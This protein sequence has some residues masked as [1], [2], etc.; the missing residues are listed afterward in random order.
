[1]TILKKIQ[2]NKITPVILGGGENGLG[3]VWSF[4]EKN[5]YSVVVDCTKSIAFYSRYTKGILVEDPITAEELFIENLI[6]IGKDLKNGFLLATNDEWLIPINKYRSKLEPY[7]KYPMSG[8]ETIQTCSDKKLLYSF[9][10]K[11]A[12]PYPKT[13]YLENIFEA[14]NQKLNFPAIL[15]PTIT[16]G[17]MEKLQLKRRTILIENEKELN[18]WITKLEKLELANNKYVIQEYIPGSVENLYTITSYSNKSGDIVAW[19]TGYKIRQ[20]P[21][22][23]GTILSGRVDPQEE[24]YKLGARLIKL[25]GFYGIANTEF[26]KDDRDGSYKLIEINPR[27][28]K[29]NRSVLATGIN[30]PYMAYSELLGDEIKTIQKNEKIIVWLSFIEDFYNALFGFKRKGFSEFSLNLMQ[31][32]NSIKGKKVLSTWNIKDIKPFF[33]HI[34]ELLK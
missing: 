20:R 1:M 5:I 11:H 32:V 10:E 9:A 24:L 26:K 15:K 6:S 28:G 30:M 18:N 31:Y 25:V 23:A 34:K 22:D 12:I 2:R 3:L 17:F 16:V 21:P 27:P 14:Q 7:F 19:S 13:F 8:W 29:W 33:A 4:S